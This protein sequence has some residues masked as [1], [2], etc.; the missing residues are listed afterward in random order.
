MV[1]ETHTQGGFL[2][3]LMTSPFIVSEL[4]VSSKIYIC[5]LIVVYVYGAYF[6]SVLP[7][8]DMKGSY[9]SKKIPFMYK[10]LGKHLKHRG[11]TH[12][13]TFLMMLWVCIL[14]LVELAERDFIVTLFFYGLLIGYI[15]HIILDL[16]TSDGVYLFAPYKK[17]IKIAN[18]KTNSNEEKRMKRFLELGTFMALGANCYILITL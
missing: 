3:A 1:K 5:F 10:L 15:S 8:I 2:L 17:V 9:I 12:S 7:D 4:K 16:F 13:L 14:S 18:L 6:G 11:I